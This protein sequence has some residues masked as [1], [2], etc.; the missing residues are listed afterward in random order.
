MDRQLLRRDMHI[1]II[2]LIVIGVIACVCLAI[3]IL[4]AIVDA[5]LFVS[6]IKAMGG[7][8]KPNKRKRH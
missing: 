7:Y 4:Y 1:V 5:I 2:T 3:A 6:I 8:V